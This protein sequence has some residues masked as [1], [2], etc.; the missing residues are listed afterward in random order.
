MGFSHK[1]FMGF[2]SVFLCFP[3]NYNV[4]EVVTS[5]TLLHAL[6]HCKGANE[7]LLHRMKQGWRLKLM[8]NHGCNWKEIC[9][10]PTEN[11]ARDL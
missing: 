10:K 9:Y 7:P 1:S 4:F 8:S 2:F 3:S 5:D 11:T 6:P